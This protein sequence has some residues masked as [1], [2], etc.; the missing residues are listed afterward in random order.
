MSQVLKLKMAISC[1]YSKR[2]WSSKTKPL[3]SWNLKTKESQMSEIC[4]NRDY[5]S[6]KKNPN[7]SESNSKTS[8]SKW[9]STDQLLITS[10]V[11]T[12]SK[13]IQTRIIKIN[14]M[15]KRAI[16]KSWGKKCKSCDSNMRASLRIKRLSC[17]IEPKSCSRLNEGMF[18]WLKQTRL[19]VIHYQRCMRLQTR[20]CV[21]SQEVVLSKVQGLDSL[22]QFKV[23]PLIRITKLL[24]LPAMGLDHVLMILDRRNWLSFLKASTLMLVQ[25]FQ[26]RVKPKLHN[27]SW[28]VEKRKKAAYKVKGTS[29]K[30]HKT[31]VQEVKVI[32]NRTSRPF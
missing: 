27:C 32:T 6:C 19:W 20:T 24:E 12:K 23:S 29:K 22:L 16:S 30:S 13:A 18:H 28:T 10:T 11:T 1:N 4:L 25:A 21:Y 31:K 2:R 8:C 26:W 7:N 9:W 14:R 3:I 17:R 15:L 5:C